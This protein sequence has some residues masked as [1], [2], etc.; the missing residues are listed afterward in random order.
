MLVIPAIDL[1]QGSCVRLYRGDYGKKT[2]YSEDPVK[3]ALDFQAAGFSRLHVV[4]LEG[5]RGGENRNRDAMRRIIETLHIPVQVGGGIRSGKDVVDF[6]RWGAHYLILST[7][8]LEDPERVSRWFQRWSAKKFIISLDVRAGRLWS[9]GWVEE[10][11]VQLE[12]A[13]KYLGSW[14]LAQVICTDIERDGTLR[15]PNFLTY[16]ELLKR[17]PR[18]VSLIAAGGISRPE[19][20]NQ[21]EHLGVQGAIVGRALYEEGVSWKEWVH[22]G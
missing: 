1:I 18:S 21:L 2:T 19:H 10:S 9:Q 11:S 4:D 13:I 15:K 8:A 12:E 7:L 22:V 16:S 14:G 5:A 3:K 6:L 17:L 20:V